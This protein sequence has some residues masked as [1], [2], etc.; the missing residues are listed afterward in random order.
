RQIL[1]VDGPS[2][3]TIS[4]WNPVR[5]EAATEGSSHSIFEPAGVYSPL[6]SRGTT[7]MP[8]LFTAQ[9]VT[10][11]SL[12]PGSTVLALARSSLPTCPRLKDSPS[13]REA[14]VVK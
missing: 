1:L 7:G 3:L 14:F 13:P 8:M 10:S 2:L 6:A 5:F 12:L 9:T 11:T 4:V